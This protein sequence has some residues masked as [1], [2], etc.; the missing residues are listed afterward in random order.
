MTNQAI[1]RKLQSQ[2]SNNGCPVAIYDETSTAHRQ[3]LT[4]ACNPGP[5]Q[6]PLGMHELIVSWP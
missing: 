6:A 2:Q 5:E 1:S 3:R 4:R